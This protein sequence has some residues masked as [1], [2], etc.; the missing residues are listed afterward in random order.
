MYHFGKMQHQ[1]IGLVGQKV[2]VERSADTPGVGGLKEEMSLGYSPDNSW[3]LC[4]FPN[5]E[6]GSWNDAGKE[7]G[8]GFLPVKCTAS[9]FASLST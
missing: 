3:L 7:R 5:Q 4:G 1:I 2:P 6:M 8:K 9:I